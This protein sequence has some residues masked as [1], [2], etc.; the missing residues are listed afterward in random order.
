[1]THTH[2]GE[3]YLETHQGTYTT[4]GAIKK[5]NRLV[6]RKLHDAEALAVLVGDDSRSVLEPHWR[7]VLLNQFHDILPG[8]DHRAGR[9]RGPREPRAH[10][11]RARRVHRRAGPR[12]AGLDRLD[13]RLDHRS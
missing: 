13:H 1:M 8:L 5:D 11:W 10:R 2:V 12:A 3:L 6:E 7:D 9:P 4:Q